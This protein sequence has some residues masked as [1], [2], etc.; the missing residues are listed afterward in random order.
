MLTGLFKRYTNRNSF[1]LSKA[2]G[3]SRSRSVPS[4]R[5]PVSTSDTLSKWS[6]YVNMLGNLTEQKVKVPSYHFG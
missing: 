4:T 5:D 2:K 6:L 3:A 1:F